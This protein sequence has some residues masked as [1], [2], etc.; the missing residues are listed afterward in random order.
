VALGCTALLA[1]QT[2]INLAVNVGFLPTTGLTL[3]FISYGGSSLCTSAIALG[4]IF[5]VGSQYKVVLA[6]EYFK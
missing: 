3:P 2:F 5:N 1:V 6:D 4:L